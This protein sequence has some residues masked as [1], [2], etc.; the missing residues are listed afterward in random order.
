MSMHSQIL[1]FSLFVLALPLLAGSARLAPA[2]DD[3]PE[4]PVRARFEALDA[5]RDHAGL[6]ELWKTHP[7]R[8][9]V[10]ID[11]DL[12]SAL[13]LHEKGGDPSEIEALHARA[14]RGAVA[15]DEAWGR[16]IIGDY[17]SAFVG[18]NAKEKKQFRAGQAACRASRQ[19]LKD[20]DAHKSLAEARRCLDLARPLGDWWGTAMGWAAIGDA[21]FAAG[22]HEESIV[23]YGA[24]R[25]LYHDLALGGSAYRVE[26]GLARA[27]AAAQRHS[28]CLRTIEWVLPTAKK[29]ND[30]SAVELLEELQLD[31]KKALGQNEAAEKAR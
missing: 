24:A 11:R 12:E 7:G 16:P 21:A 27:L 1:H 22:S 2:D 14:R 15:A 29:R 5:A 8:V 18:W 17:V 6:V 4:D 30:H 10:T 31:A 28:R 23:A 19:A 25:L 9:L 13:A 20:G 26:L 3:P